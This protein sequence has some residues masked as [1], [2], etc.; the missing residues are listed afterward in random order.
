MAGKE[1]KLT[2][3]LEYGHAKANG[4][5]TRAFPHIRYGENIAKENL[6]NYLKEE[7]E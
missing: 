7:I 3:L 6:V 4:G 1:A 2:H 5:R